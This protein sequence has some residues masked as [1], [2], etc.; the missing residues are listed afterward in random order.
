MPVQPALS[1]AQGQLYISAVNHSNGWS[2]SPAV[3]AGAR[4]Q[5]AVAQQVKAV[6]GGI[7]GR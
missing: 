7:P 4:T 6:G 2:Y 5:Q 3:G 1:P